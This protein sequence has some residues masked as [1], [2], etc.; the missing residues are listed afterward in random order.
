MIPFFTGQLVDIL[1]NKCHIHEKEVDAESFGSTLQKRMR[2][3]LRHARET[4][5]INERLLKN[6]PKGLYAKE[7]HKVVHQSV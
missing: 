3:K 6:V 2:K 1:E 7:K 4:I 5:S